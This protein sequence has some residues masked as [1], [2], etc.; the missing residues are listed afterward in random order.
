MA[1]SCST[2]LTCDRKVRTK[3][4]RPRDRTYLVG[5]LPGKLERR[6]DRLGTRVHGQDHLKP[7]KLSDIL[8]EWSE[9]G[10]VE[11]A[12]GK[13]QLGRLVD[14]GL[15]DFGVAV[16]YFGRRADFVRECGLRWI[17]MPVRTLVDSTAQAK[18]QQ[19]PPLEPKR[20][21]KWVTSR[22]KG[23]RCIGS[24]GKTD[25]PREHVPRVAKS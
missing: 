19:K 13:G 21:E 7:G 24:P 18:D 5:P 15:H 20:R 3:T 6:L 16:T 9:G 23:S 4:P 1:L 14:E 11:R 8:R 17:Q 12:R 2:P 22:R 25:E 10:G